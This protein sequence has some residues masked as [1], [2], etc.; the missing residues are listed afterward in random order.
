MPFNQPDLSHNRPAHSRLL[1]VRSSVG[2]YNFM[3]GIDLF[4]VPREQSVV[5]KQQSGILFDPFA[6]RARSFKQPFANSGVALQFLK[7]LRFYSEHSPLLI[8]SYRFGILIENSPAVA[9]SL[10]AV[11]HDSY[12]KTFV[13]FFKHSS[14]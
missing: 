8:Q 3:L 5:L 9:C 14:A 13:S 11:E 1:A 7:R 2:A 4:E 12:E 10:Y 6:S